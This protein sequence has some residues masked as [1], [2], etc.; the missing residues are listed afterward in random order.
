MGEKDRDYK[1]L[2]CGKSIQNYFTCMENNVAGFTKR[3]AKK[4]DI[5]YFVVNYEKVSYL[6]A[7]GLLNP[8]N[9]ITRAEAVS[10]LS[11]VKK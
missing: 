8:T 2:N 9:N 4:G 5:V 1:F 7:K 11:R 3:F 6:T 10:M